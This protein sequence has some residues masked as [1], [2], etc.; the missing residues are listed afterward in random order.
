[1][2]KGDLASIDVTSDDFATFTWTT[3][4]A[5]ATDFTSPYGE[6][7]PGACFECGIAARQRAWMERGLSSS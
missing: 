2:Q 3:N 1:M 5:T 6:K 4:V 7:R